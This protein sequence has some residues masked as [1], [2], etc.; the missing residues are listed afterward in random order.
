MDD[1]TG[2]HKGRENLGRLSQLLHEFG[3]VFFIGLI[4]CRETL[5]LKFGLWGHCCH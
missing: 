4:I 2:V 3:G 1:L 5:G